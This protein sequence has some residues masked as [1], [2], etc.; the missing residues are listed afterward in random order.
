MTGRKY[1]CSACLVPHL[2]PTGKGCKQHLTAH[3]Q[4]HEH[5][6]NPEGLEGT[7]NTVPAI[8]TA[9]G[10]TPEDIEVGQPPLTDPQ[11]EILETQQVADPVP[12]TS[13]GGP[14]PSGPNIN[15]LV[16]V[17]HEQ[18][19][20]MELVT[21]QIA[22][23]AN[24]LGELQ[25]RVHSAPAHPN[26][27]GDGGVASLLLR[28]QQLENQR[29]AGIAV[30]GPVSGTGA[31]SAHHVSQPMGVDEGATG[32]A[33]PVP[34]ADQAAGRNAQ[35]GIASQTGAS[36]QHGATAAAPTSNIADAVSR[37]LAELG[38]D[39]ELDVD[40]SE[41]SNFRRRTRRS[42]MARTVEDQ[43]LVEIDWPHFH[44]YRGNDRR[45]ARFNELTPIEF[46]YGFMMM[47]N[48]P[49][50]RFDRVVMTDL[51]TDILTDALSFPWEQVR[52]FYRVVASGVEMKR[53][54]WTDSAQIQRLRFQYSQRP[55]LPSTY[56]R[57]NRT[58]GV[59]C[60]PFQRGACTET[61]D[62]GNFR[63]VCAYCLRIRHLH[64]GHSE[65]DCRRKKQ[66]EPKNFREGE[67]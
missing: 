46:A 25:Q 18:S 1:L 51:F 8:E 34:V 19:G 52:N 53:W 11:N 6:E 57:Q 62:H 3:G 56:N 28:V 63:H 13:T 38:L 24:A 61:A 31:Q 27:T 43:V 15:E 37:R 44:L 22:S 20:L 10:E 55:Y 45:P 49:Q 35:Q 29:S 67:Q 17:I 47:L 21:G 12:G 58:G 54:T 40:D 30:A 66:N 4:H 60:E 59:P 14:T 65:N 42:G 36:R 9:T 32:G 23:I 2:P 7:L 16:R 64:F 50:S 5:G 41:T 48:N 26:P 39:D 33:A